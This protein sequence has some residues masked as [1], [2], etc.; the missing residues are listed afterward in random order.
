MHRYV[1]VIVILIC[2]ATNPGWSAEWERIEEEEARI[3]FYPPGLSNG[4]FHK[5]DQNYGN[6]ELGNWRGIGGMPLAGIYSF[7]LFPDRVITRE[8]KLE[9]VTRNWEVFND[10]TL[11]TSQ[12][13]RTSNVV[14]S[15]GYQ[16]FTA[17]DLHCVS[18]LQSWGPHGWGDNDIGIPRNQING[19]YCDTSAL[20][21]RTVD[22]VLKGIGV[23]GHKVPANPAAR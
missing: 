2:F 9:D 23:R 6:E 11:K 22:G 7:R 13:N 14:S 8:S 15:I 4:T 21:D 18:F 19:Y 16:L 17:D 1:T 5:R 12:V 10:K 3:V 20:S